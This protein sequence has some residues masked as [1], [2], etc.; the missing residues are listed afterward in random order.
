MLID[1]KLQN[2]WAFNLVFQECF[3]NKSVSNKNNKALCLLINPHLGAQAIIF[4]I[5]LI[6][7]HLLTHTLS[8]GAHKD[9]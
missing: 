8:S 9:Q 6:S 7:M 4:G 3:V 2:Q 5:Y 1:E